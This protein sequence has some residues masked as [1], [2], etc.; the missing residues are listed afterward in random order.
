MH[1]A[2][3][4]GGTG[5]SPEKEPVRDDEVVAKSRNP[6]RMTAPESSTPSAPEQQ[7]TFTL[8]RQISYCSEAHTHSHTHTFSAM[9]KRAA[10]SQHADTGVTGR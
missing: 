7:I 8:T 6:T 10:G 4:G 3:G 5:S 2:G 1:G 9:E